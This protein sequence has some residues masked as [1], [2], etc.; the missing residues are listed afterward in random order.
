[1]NSV[2]RIE[3]I[4]N[5][6]Q[7]I[8]GEIVGRKKLHKLIYLCQARAIDFG[9]NFVFH[10]YGVYSPTLCMDLE[11]A[12]QWD[13]LT[14]E[15]CGTAFKIKLKQKD[16]KGLDCIGE[17]NREFISSL[18]DQSASVLEVLSTLIYLDKEGFKNSS[19]YSKLHELKPH[20]EAYFPQ[21]QE[22]AEDYYGM[23]ATE[24]IE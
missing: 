11:L 8:G 4:Q 16:S 12:R 3:L 7:L 6:L 24:P 20:L 23:K 1:M 9:Q 10:F 22:L 13:L 18:A 14:E 21:A 5:C 15:Q 2:R 17:D 19:L